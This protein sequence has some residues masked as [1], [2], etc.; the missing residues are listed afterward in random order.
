MQQCPCLTRLRVDDRILR[1]QATSTLLSYNQILS[2]NVVKT[3]SI[4]ISALTVP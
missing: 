4:F 2:Y 1:V 3:L